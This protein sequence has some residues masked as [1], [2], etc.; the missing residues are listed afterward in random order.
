MNRVAALAVGG[1]SA[2]DYN[3]VILPVCN[4]N[5]G[6]AVTVRVNF[7]ALRDYD[8]IV[9]AVKAN[10]RRAVAV[11]P[12][13]CALNYVVVRAVDVQTDA[14]CRRV[15]AV[16]VLTVRPRRKALVVYDVLV[17]EINR[18][19]VE[20][21]SVNV[22]ADVLQKCQ[23]RFHEGGVTAIILVAHHGAGKFEVAEIRKSFPRINRN[24]ADLN[25]VA[26][27]EGFSAECFGY[28]VADEVKISS[29][30]AN[31]RIY[32]FDDKNVLGCQISARRRQESVLNVRIV[33]ICGRH[34][35]LIRLR[36]QTVLV[37]QVRSEIVRIIC[38]SAYSVKIF[39]AVCE[40]I[41]IIDPFS[42]NAQTVS[43]FVEHDGRNFDV[44]QGLR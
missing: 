29:S 34:N 8:C 2:V 44:F 9:V 40:I 1:D 12:N 13:I 41:G 28:V 24:A 23:F 37:S 36:C 35:H 19:P 14:Q 5:A 43:D 6:A 31:F 25:A 10:A 33:K 22:V 7:C 38:S 30:K 18:T 16:D 11:R 27:R 26:A 15:I 39:V 4:E 21:F 17:V 32:V 42:G 20:I 3:V